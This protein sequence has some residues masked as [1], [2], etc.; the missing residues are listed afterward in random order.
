[1]GRQDLQS[2]V[3]EVMKHLEKEDTSS[4]VPIGVSARHCHLNKESLE[5][6]FGRGYELS[7]KA[8][9]SQPGQFAANETVTVAGPKG[10]IPKVRILGPLRSSSQVEVS[11]TDAFKLGLKPPIRQSGHTEN[12]SPVTIIGP[13]GSIYLEEGL[14]IA[15][16]HIHMSP[17]DADN[18]KVK[19]G[20][21]V[22][23]TVSNPG[24]EVSFSKTI[25]RVSE[26][27][28]LEMHIDTDEAN[29]GLIQTG[30]KGSLKKVEPSY[31]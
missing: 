23:V 27:Y 12:S 24:R 3:E 8:P 21:V 9:L 28:R 25:I 18:F 26:K 11:Q 15:Q 1:M 7:E 31:V 10:S 29:A 16:A 17:Q 5:I 4:E 2:I 22:E 13:K 19:D 6:L 14:I 30:Q 20:Q